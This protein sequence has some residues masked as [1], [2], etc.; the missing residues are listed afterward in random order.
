MKEYSLPNLDKP[1][2]DTVLTVHRPRSIARGPS[3]TTSGHHIIMKKSLIALLLCSSCTLMECSD[4]VYLSQKEFTGNSEHTEMYVLTTD[5]NTYHFG[6]LGYQIKGDT[7]Y[8]RG[9]H[10]LSGTTEIP[11]KGVI[12]MSDIRSFQTQRVN[13]LRTTLFLT[14][15]VAVSAAVITAVTGSREIQRERERMQFLWF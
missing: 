10:V 7:L 6:S 9:T 8:G 14:G 2:T 4:T 15:V 1:G 5:S 3:S 13:A 12:P 11:F